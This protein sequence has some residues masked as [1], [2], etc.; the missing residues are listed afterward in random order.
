LVACQPA[1][2]VNA[3]TTRFVHPRQFVIGVWQ[4][5]RMSTASAHRS[6]TV[7]RTTPGRFAISNIRGG[8][9]TV[10]TGGD[11]DFS[12]TELLLGAIGACTA[13]DVDTVTSRR[14]EPDAFEVRV[15]AT[16]VKDDAGNRLTDIE[17]TF[18]LAFPTGEAGDNA[19]A[20]LPEAVRRSHDR[21]CTV[22]RTVEDG[23]PIATR[24]ID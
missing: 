16:K 17:V 20:L 21:W 18:K 2:V 7:E 13:I 10:G 24:I 19:R 14:A 1:A 22:G 5:L 11:A 9:I 3:P 23:T 15:D 6:V 12:P 4:G 8:K